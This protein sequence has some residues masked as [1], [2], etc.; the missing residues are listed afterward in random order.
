[1]AS[2]KARTKAKNILKITAALTSQGLLNDDE[3][4]AV[5]IGTL[6]IIMDTRKG[7][8]PDKQVETFGKQ[9]TQATETFMK[10]ARSNANIIP[11]SIWDEALENE[12]GEA[13]A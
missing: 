4:Q 3:E 7:G 9:I 11:D 1:M 12:V 10:N 5:L 13:N 8:K 2:E 6:P